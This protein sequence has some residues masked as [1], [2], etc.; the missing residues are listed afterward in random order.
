MTELLWIRLQS[1][2][3]TVQ[4]AGLDVEPISYIIKIKLSRNSRKG[5]VMDPE[6]HSNVRFARVLYNELKKRKKWTKRKFILQV[7]RRETFSE[8]RAIAVRYQFRRKVRSE[9]TSHPSLL[10]NPY[11]KHVRRYGDIC[12]LC[13]HIYLYELQSHGVYLRFDTF[14]LHKCN[15]CNA[16]P[17]FE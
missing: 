3:L 15:E 7:R 8:L 6:I 1:C 10:H 11:I 9:V 5:D 4:V 13:L 17:V 14:M 12:A 2:T 16:V